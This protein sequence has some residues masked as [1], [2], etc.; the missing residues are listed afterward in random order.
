[1]RRSLAQALRQCLH[2]FRAEA[3]GGAGGVCAPQSSKSSAWTGGR[4]EGAANVLRVLCGRQARCGVG[5]RGEGGAL[6]RSPPI[7]DRTVAISARD[8]NGLGLI[9]ELTQRLTA[10]SGINL[11]VGTVP[12]NLLVHHES[13][14]STDNASGTE[15]LRRLQ[16]E[17]GK[18]NKS[19][20]GARDAQVTARSA[21][22][23]AGSLFR[24][25]RRTQHV[26]CE[27]HQASVESN[28]EP[29]TPPCARAFN[30]ADAADFEPERERSWRPTTSDRPTRRA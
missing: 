4:A 20:A 14:I 27:G 30:A 3:C 17:D 28:H 24:I 2:R 7:L 15:I 9:E 13:R 5:L 29:S 6:L 25:D 12:T 22:V 26:C 21:V 23:A 16:R 10:G 1:M 11:S 18:G 8:R 19:V